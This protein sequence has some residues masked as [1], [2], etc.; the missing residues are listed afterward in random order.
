MIGISV[1]VDGIE[2]IQRGFN[3]LEKIDD[4]RPIWPEVT[5][6][7]HA[8]E[9]EQFD[10]EGAA[11][12]GKWEPLSPVYAEYKEIQYPGKPILQASGAL[13]ESLVTEG[14]P[15]GIHRET[16]DE[17]VLG[18]SINY[19]LFHQRGTRKMPKRS[20]MN[21]SEQQ[22]RRIQKAVQKG[23]IQFVRDA[24]FGEGERAA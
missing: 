9:Q 19:G 8:I 21:F 20:P 10:T 17:L 1:T 5:K 13:M 7:F 11:G 3:R 2:T 24:G 14:A 6:E 4:W 23:L 15:G 18:T 16:S 12:G 22:K